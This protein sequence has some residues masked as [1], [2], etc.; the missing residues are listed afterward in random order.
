MYYFLLPFMYLSSCL[1]HKKV[2]I[3]ALVACSVKASVLNKL[4]S[5]WRQQYWSLGYD[6]QDGSEFLTCPNPL[7]QLCIADQSSCWCDLNKKGIQFYWQFKQTLMVFLRLIA[8]TFR[9]NFSIMLF[10][11]KFFPNIS[12]CFQTLFLK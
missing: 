1:S 4:A 8:L 7:I 12:F 11:L 2:I 3:A 6:C 10:N 9:F 5:W